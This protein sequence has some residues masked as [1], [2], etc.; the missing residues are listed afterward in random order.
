[1]RPNN[2]PAFDYPHSED[3]KKHFIVASVPRSGSTLLCRGLWSTKLAGAPKEYFNRV[4]IADFYKRWQF[5]NLEQYCQ[6]LK[7]HRTSPNGV[8][9]I[10]SHIR[11]LQDIAQHIDIFRELPD[12]K[13]IYV[14][15]EDKMRQAVS[16]EYG[17]QTGR[18]SSDDQGVDNAQYNPQ[19]IMECLQEVVAAEQGW[20]QFFD[21][22]K[23]EPIRV[24]YES[25]AANYA[26]T[27]RDLLSYLEIEFSTQDTI[28]EPDIVPLAS[29]TKQE[30]YE[31]IHRLQSAGSLE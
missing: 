2:G 4:H 10:K 26:G 3:V 22:H 5:Q 23:I 14:Y 24:A 9:G 12:A 17:R 25:L 6:L 28:P 20:S 15:R 11:Q 8:F 16:F 18:W 27:I 7:Q 29:A 1:M 21:T 30:W 31:K 19:G 13:F